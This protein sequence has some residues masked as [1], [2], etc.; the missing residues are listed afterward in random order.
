A[1]AAPIDAAPADAAPTDAGPIIC[2]GVDRACPESVPL[3]GSAC[4]GDLECRYSFAFPDCTDPTVRCIDGRWA[5]PP[6]IPPG[7]QLAEGCSDPEVG[8]FSG[9]AL[10]VE[11]PTELTWGFQGNAMIEFQVAI[12]PE[13]DAPGCVSIR[14]RLTFDGETVESRRPVRLRCGR[15]LSVQVI[16]PGLPCDDRAY[17]GSLE[18]EV[19]GLATQTIAFSLP[20]GQPAG[21]GRPVCDTTG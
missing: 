12:D 8:P 2:D 6:C 9:L 18:V 20:G 5:H 17:A 16:V 14:S 15:S 10:T 1:D 7:P 4:A 11:P 19:L 3:S 21:S 13:D